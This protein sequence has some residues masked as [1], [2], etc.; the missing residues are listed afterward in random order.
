MKEFPVVLVL[1]PS[2]C[3]APEE[4]M[5]RGREVPSSANWVT[6]NCFLPL[7]K[8]IIRQCYVSE[9]AGDAQWAEPS[10]LFA[11]MTRP[12]PI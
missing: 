4:R 2:Q 1:T 6:A 8:D 11:L 9:F 12:N 3:G 5:T 7:D 10:Q